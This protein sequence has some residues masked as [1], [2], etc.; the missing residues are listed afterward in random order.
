MIV[1]RNP[2]RL[3]RLC[4]NMVF[5]VLLSLVS[6]A[7]SQEPLHGR[8]DQLIA[9]LHS[10]PEVPTATDA[11][12][13]R[14]VSLDLVG[15]IPTAE[16][17][18]KFIDDQSPNKR[19]KL[20]DQLLASPA[21]V[22]HMVNVF[23]VML[24]ERRADKYLKGGE[25]QKYLLASFE[26]NKPYDQ[27]AR[28]ILGADGVDEK[29]R[30]PAKFYL[31][32]E[33]EPNLLTREIGRMFFGMDLQCAQC[34]DHPIVD[35]YLQSDYY[36]VYAFISRSY[37]F[38]PDAKK[39]AVVA[40]K[41]EGDAKYK[42]VFTA[43]EG[44]TPPR[45]PGEVEVEDP[46]FAKGDEYTVKPDPKKKNIRPIPK[47][48]RRAQLAALAT[49]GSNHAFNRNIVNR[50]WAH[51]M[52]R[53][54]VS[55][56]D[57]H[58][59]DNPPAH[60]ELLDLLATEFVAMKFDVKA[61]VR[62]LTLSR[63]YQRGIQ[64]PAD[65][66]PHIAAARE[67]SP[68]LA[69][70]LVQHE[71]SI[72]QLKQTVTAA[73]AHLLD[74]KKAAA[75]IEEEWK[76]VDDALAIANKAANDAAKALEDAQQQLSEKRPV[77]KLLEEAAA[78]AKLAAD[79]LPEDK[80][81]AAVLKTLRTKQQ[82]VFGQVEQL[83]KRVTERT[84]VVQAASQKQTEAQATADAVAAKRKEPKQKVD[85]ARSQ[86]LASQ[87]DTERLKTVTSQVKKQVAKTAATVAVAESLAKLSKCQSLVDQLQP[88]LAS[89]QQTLE[90]VAQQNAEELVRVAAR[91]K[92]AEIAVQLE[93]ATKNLSE[94]R[95]YVA[96]TRDLV[97]ESWSSDFCIAPVQP[98]SPEQIAWSVIQATGQWDRQRI[99]SKAELD[100][101]SPPKPEEQTDAAKVAARK[102]QIEMAA[103]GK[104]KPIVDKFIGLYGGGSGQPQN[105][106]FATVDQALFF[107][108][109]GEVRGWL[110]ASG[111]NLTDR[112]VKMDDPKAI[113]EELYLSVLTRRPTDEEAA[114]V[115]QYLSSR[116]EEKSAVVQ[117]MAWAL[118]TSAEFRFHH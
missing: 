9:Q 6:V 54:L 38:Q 32:R 103:Y 74:A 7:V 77:A 58:H 76:K 72:E 14:R 108:N 15:M 62:E 53:G 48:S 82:Q 40:E 25:W 5:C 101:K 86:L 73:R 83:A 93:D 116:P 97:A 4:T 47:Y 88:Q 55:P 84:P 91:E 117:E 71:Q 78:K 87:T 81:V 75:P 99:A 16:E 60:P 96:V 66:N 64:L 80:D 112:L 95:E 29:L 12:F 92:A 49:D 8:I 110:A 107:A 52:G 90:Q 30:G 13:I 89:A 79:K 67:N 35:D 106:F 19:S 51:V 34:H 56:V 43:E 98:L 37:K 104:L 31:E 21:Y 20:V 46:T 118:L 26:Q 69:A 39:P 70:A 113:A 18:R 85:T 22:R 114:D 45:L 68:S 33:V 105:E 111:G 115:Q 42:S 2:V 57:M 24:M 36:G 102:L 23:D 41:A 109:G 11:E 1:P 100:K 94:A 59:F 44:T 63:T 27:L 65:L 28:E 17:A 50:L 61:F 3:G 10:G